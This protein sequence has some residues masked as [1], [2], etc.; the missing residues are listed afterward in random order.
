VGYSGQFGIGASSPSV[1]ILQLDHTVVMHDIEN[2]ER[3][4]LLCYTNELP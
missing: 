2:K 4:L 3:R 1:R